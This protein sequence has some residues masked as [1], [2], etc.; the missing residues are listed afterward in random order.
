M[1]S[2]SKKIHKSGLTILT[3]QHTSPAITVNLYI[4][5]GS[6]NEDSTNRGIS[7]Y[8]EHMLFTGTTNREKYFLTSYIE[9]IGASLN[10]YTSYSETALTFSC[11][12]SNF[13]ECLDTM[14]DMCF[15]TS[16]IEAEVENERKIILQEIEDRNQSLASIAYE[17]YVKDMWSKNP[18]METMIIGTTDSVKNI[19]REQLM[20]YYKENYVPNRMTLSVCGNFDENEIDEI[21]EKFCNGESEPQKK[22]VELI[23]PEQ[24]ES[25]FESKFDQDDIKILY[26]VNINSYR[27]YRILSLVNRVLGVGMSSLL[28]QEIREKRGLVYG[29]GSGLSF[30]STINDLHLSI[31]TQCIPTKTDQILSLVP[32]IVKSLENVTEEDIQYAKNKTLFGLAKSYDSSNFNAANNSEKNEVWGMLVTYDSEVEVINSITIDEFKEMASRF[33]NLTPS[34]VVT[35]S[36]K[37]S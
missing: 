6:L 27:E 19:T 31:G 34:T 11:M 8:L 32:G 36:N 16:F 29:I 21:V 30:I 35:K 13:E 25:T 4:N 7:H 17:N 26:P 24:H 9:N 33:I 10:A 22:V 20:D 1:T 12:T 15:N 2:P 14:F 18:A 37:E 5:T 28:F 3:Q 23:R